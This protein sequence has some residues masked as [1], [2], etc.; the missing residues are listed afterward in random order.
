MRLATGLVAIGLGLMAVALVHG[1]TAG[2]FRAEGRTLLS[3]PW[4]RVSLVDVYVG[5]ALFS[6]WVVYRERSASRAVAWIVLVATLGNLVSCLYVLLALRRHAGD[7]PG[8]WLGRRRE[9][10]G[11]A[12]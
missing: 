3:I 4:G 2:D 6:G 10:P 1:F 8:F 11:D 9:A 5:F 12:R 7:W